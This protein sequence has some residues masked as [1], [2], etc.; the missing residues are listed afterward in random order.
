MGTIDGLLLEIGDN[1]KN[2]NIVKDSVLERLK[3]DGNLTEKQ[4]TD[5]RE[6]WQ[7]IIV[8]KSWFT[9]WVEKHTKGDKNGYYF[10]FVK[11]EE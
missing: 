2:A 5:Y 10:K 9:S 8:K 6:K 3:L 1:T 11:F 4:A 7:I